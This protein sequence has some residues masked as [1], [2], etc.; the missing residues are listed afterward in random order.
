MKTWWGA[1][2][3]CIETQAHLCDE[4]VASH[5]HARRSIL[6]P[7]RAVDRNFG[8]RCRRE[9][10]CGGRLVCPCHVRLV[11]CDKNVGKV[12][13]A[14]LQGCTDLSHAHGT[15]IGQGFM[16]NIEKYQNN[17]GYAINNNCRI[18]ISLLVK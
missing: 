16:D 14:I 12:M 5:A 18:V 10:D 1:G 6:S 11:E 13:E 4:K 15:L 8:A 9:G 3:Y 17:Q 7:R 2:V